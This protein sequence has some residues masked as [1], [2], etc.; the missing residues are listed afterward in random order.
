[1]LLCPSTSFAPHDS[2]RHA[3]AYQPMCFTVLLDYKEGGELDCGFECRLLVAQAR[4]DLSYEA[5][6]LDSCI[7]AK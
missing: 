7:Q 2:S 4:R 1:M 3:Y 5:I 6:P